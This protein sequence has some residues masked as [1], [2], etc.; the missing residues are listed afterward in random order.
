MK[1]EAPRAYR[2]RH[3]RLA[4]DAANLLEIL[5]LLEQA[6]VIVWIDGGWGVDALLGEQTR[7][8]DDLDLV[9]ELVHV[10]SLMETL[11]SNGY[12]LVAGSPPTSF[13]HVDAVGRQ[14][15]VH[16]VVFDETG[17]G[18]YRMEDGR[19]WIYPANGFAGR[20]R[21]GGQP[22]RCLTAEVQVLVHEG[23]ELADKDYRELR[24]LHERFGVHLPTSVRA[25]ALATRNPE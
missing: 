24:L 4:T 22:V 3:P 1:D 17:G 7:E 21:V 12:E 14:V 13:V 18:V 9:V 20:G 5:N 8:H 25:R 19:D 2:D 23:Y 11:T 10:P 15:D 6:G 16:P